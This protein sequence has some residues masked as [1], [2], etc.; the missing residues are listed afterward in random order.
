M[1]APLHR[2]VKTLGVVSLLT[3]ASSEMIY[4]LLPAFL[5]GPLRAG[6]ALLGVIEG[7]AETVAA[8]AK[9]ASGHLSDRM[10]RRKPLMVAG[11]GVSSVARPLLALAVFPVHVLGV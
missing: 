10:P 4:P 7:L 1:R 2:N 3:D 9:V 8:L 11:Y 6:P 5:T